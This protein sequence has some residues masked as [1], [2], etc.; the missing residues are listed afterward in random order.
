MTRLTRI[1]F[2]LSLIQLSSSADAAQRIA[3]LNFELNDITSLPDTP[4]ELQRTASMAPLLVQALSQT[5]DY[6]IVAV[7]ANTQKAANAGFGYLFRFH[8]QAAQLGQQ[9]GADWII[10]SQHSKPSFLESYLIAHL[11]RVK[12]QTL[13]ARYDIALKGNHQKVTQHG[14]NRLADNIRLLIDR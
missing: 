6:E 8:D 14:V 3:I 2:L 9:L 10:V 11:I 12:T 5:G 13:A 7:D 4:A 1:A